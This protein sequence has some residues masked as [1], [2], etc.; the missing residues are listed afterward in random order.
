MSSVGTYSPEFT[1]LIISNDVVSH[2]VSNFAEGTFISIE[3]VSERFTPVYGA[4]GEAYRAHNPVKA[5]N[6]TVTLSQTSH[7]N[8]VLSMLL[9]LDRESL[10]GTFNLIL[11]D[12][13]GTTLFSENN[14]YIGTEPSQGFSGGGSIESRE[15]TIHL[16]SPKYNIGGNGKF[17]SEVQSDYEALGG[18]VDARWQSS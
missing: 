7:S 5:F 11:K 16:P 1:D 3:P 2:V 6:L 9:N 15:W 17:A 14:A 12:S 18:T 13:S 8:D 4:K 10:D